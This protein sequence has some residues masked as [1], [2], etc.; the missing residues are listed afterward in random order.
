M[1]KCSPYPLLK[2]FGWL[3]TRHAT[4]IADYRHETEVKSL[5]RRLDADVGGMHESFNEWA[6]P[7]D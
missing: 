1:G 5:A 6:Q 2:A 4:E 7:Q 3:Y